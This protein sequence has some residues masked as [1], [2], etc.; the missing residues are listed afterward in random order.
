MA[1]KC[2]IK[3]TNED[4]YNEI[5]LLRADFSS[6]KSRV[7]INTWCSATALSLVIGIFL[8]ILIK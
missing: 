3:V 4:V 5:K 2:F 1:N 6:I 7:K 8:G